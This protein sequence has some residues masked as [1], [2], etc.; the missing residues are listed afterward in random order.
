MA[1]SDASFEITCCAN[2]IAWIERCDVALVLIDAGEGFTDQDAKVANLTRERGRAC[3]VVANKWDLRPDGVT[4]EDFTK[5]LDKTLP[6]IGFA[7]I[8]YTSAKTGLNV[9][10]L[11]EV[12]QG[13]HAQAQTRVTTGELNKVV[14][15][16]YALRRP[17]PR[18]DEGL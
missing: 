5:Y 10:R 9:D 8:I 6:G 12:A 18:Y 3:A 4:P 15:A 1:R 14:E 13:L 7:P 16:A 2:W 17:R 11:I